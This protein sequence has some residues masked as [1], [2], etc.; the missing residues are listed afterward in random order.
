M[1]QEMTRVVDEGLFGLLD[2]AG[3]WLGQEPELSETCLQ[4]LIDIF[5]NKYQGVF[6]ALLREAHTI[7]E[8]RGDDLAG[9]TRA[10]LSGNRPVGYRREAQ[11]VP[12]ILEAFA[13]K[14]FPNVGILPFDRES[15]R[16]FGRLKFRLEKAG[17]GC[18]E[19][20]LRIAAIAIQHDLTL[21]TGN[22]KNFANIPGLA[23]ENWL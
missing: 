14:V 15:G 17:I 12:L 8:Q 6:D 9:W 4:E 7:T 21:I 11:F 20:D 22:I 18:S 2:V 5:D 19:P 1:V 23:V 16:V 13:A 10:W 3:W